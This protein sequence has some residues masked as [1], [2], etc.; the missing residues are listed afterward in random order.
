MQRIVL[1]AKAGTDQ[2][3]LADAA[4]E[5]AQQTGGVVS[6]VSVDGLESEILSPTPRDEFVAVARQTIDRA[7]DRLREQGVRAEGVV[8][9]GP[10]A[11]GV[12]LYAE[13]VDADLIVCG[14]S[15]RGRI[16]RRMLGSVPVELIG[17]SRRPVLVV[18]QPEAAA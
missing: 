11:R 16:A 9:S 8:R 6:V 5:V 14:G 4:A 18:T 12:L 1:A 13:E 2:P 10:V 3:W 7:L 15:T 17:R